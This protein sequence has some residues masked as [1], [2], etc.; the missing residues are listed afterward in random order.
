MGQIPVKTVSG[1]PDKAAAAGLLAAA[2]LAEIFADV[3]L[4]RSAPGARRAP[5]GLMPSDDPF[6]SP[7]CAQYP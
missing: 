2:S 4:T 1:S 5:A 6:A 3:F 7:P